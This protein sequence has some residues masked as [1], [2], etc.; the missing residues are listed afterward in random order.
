M[1]VLVVILPVF[2]LMLTG[3]VLKALGIVKEDLAAP[4]IQYVFYVAGPALLFTSVATIPFY[5]IWQWDFIAIYGLITLAGFLVLFILSWI[6]YTHSRAIGALY[7]L[8]ATLSNAGFIGLPILYALFGDKALV[9][10][11]LSLIVSMTILAF[12]LFLLEMAAEN[13]P[14]WYLLV[15]KSFLG[16]LKNPF[17]IGIVAGILYS[18][19]GLGLEKGVETYL[20]LFGES[21]TPCALFAIGIQ[22]SIRS[23]VKNFTHTFFLT[24]MKLVVMPAIALF[25]VVAFELTPIWGIT[26]VIASGLPTAKVCAIFAEIYSKDDEPKKIV[27]ETIAST[28]LLSILTLITW[29]LILHQFY[30]TMI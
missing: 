18:A 6:F 8:S 14:T 19:T 23:F 5:Q 7:A 27:S 20:K 2:C 17:I 22:M 21:L 13:H 4:L 25:F 24:L 1:N 3:W 9:P 15:Y 16:L 29:F 30:P 28:T 12:A 11:G 26:A 10:G